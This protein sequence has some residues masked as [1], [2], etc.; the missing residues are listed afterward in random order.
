MYEY[1]AR[2]LRVVDADT[3][4]LAVDLGCEVR[5]HLTI[6]LFGVNAPEA[7]TALGDAAT[8]FV[9]GL[10]PVGTVVTLRT[11]KDKREKFGRYLG[12]ILLGEM[13]LNDELIQQGLAVR[14]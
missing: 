8:A 10:L 6:R 14:S 1:A 13:V 9:R 12:V 5:I 7:R 11:I 4:H 2:V 3:L